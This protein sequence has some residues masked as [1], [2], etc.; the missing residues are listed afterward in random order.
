MPVTNNP[1]QNPFYNRFNDPVTRR[2]D[3]IETYAWLRKQDS[4]LRQSQT[5]TSNAPARS[6]TSP[7]T[8]YIESLN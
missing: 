6:E 3:E 4:E 5:V 8:D 7:A 1:F 2:Q